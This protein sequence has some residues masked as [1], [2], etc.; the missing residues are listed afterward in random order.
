[1]RKV[2]AIP[3]RSRETGR[4][5]FSDEPGYTLTF[6]AERLTL[7]VGLGLAIVWLAFS[8][9]AA[10][11]MATLAALP[12]SGGCSI[13]SDSPTGALST[14][15]GAGDPFG[16]TSVKEFTVEV[17]GGLGLDPACL[18]DTVETVL[19]DPR[20]WIHAGNLGWRR[21]ASGPD[22][23]IIFAS[24]A[25]TDALCAPIDTA[26]V[27]SCRNGNRAVLNVYRWRNGTSEYAN[28]LDEYRRYL[29]N[30][31]VGHFLGHGHTVCPG[32]GELAPVMMQQTKGLN[33]CAQNGWPFPLVPVKPEVWDG[34]FW[35]DD[36]SIFEADI[37]WVAAAAITLGCNPPDN[38]AYC[39]GDPVTRG[40]MAAFLDRA[41]GLP[42]TSTDFF[43]DDDGTIFEASINRLAA[44]DITR[45]CGDGT[46]F[47]AGAPITRAQMAAFLVRAFDL[48][49]SST[50]AFTDDTDSA[51]EP[52]INRLAA[53]GITAGCTPTT[54]CPTDPVTRAQM[55]A[56]LR[57]A[58]E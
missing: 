32:A 37:E 54:Y 31:E 7:A 47:C 4:I 53:S 38:D 39:P 8:A 44:A 21:V 18:A 43:S 46:A 57:R 9:G 56:F 45:G 11:P 25:L 14:V 40:Q 29:I 6:A 58:L 24:P 16:G 34:T 30:H 13:G 22:V 17:E 55:A 2:S 1:M 36:G 50:D 41:L 10:E 23:R 33:G 35:D 19:G 20:S 3:G 15:P 5:S 28:D 12:D 48:P 51:F 26:G 42:A 52:D 49:A 27:F